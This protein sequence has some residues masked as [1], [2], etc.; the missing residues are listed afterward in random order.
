PPLRLEVWNVARPVASSVPLPRVVPPSL[1][2]SVPLGV[3]APGATAVTVAVKVTGWPA[4]TGLGEE[5]SVVVV[6]AWFTTWLSMAEL[7]EANVVSPLYLGVIAC[8]PTTRA[9]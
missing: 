7:L 6:A 9:G 5:E 1:K 2:V 3:P 8:G 4:P